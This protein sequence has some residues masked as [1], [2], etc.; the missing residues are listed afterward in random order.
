MIKPRLI[1]G[2]ITLR[3]INLRP[4]GN[5]IRFVNTYLLNSRPYPLFEQQLGFRR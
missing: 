2:W 5:A 1:E 4:V 3:G